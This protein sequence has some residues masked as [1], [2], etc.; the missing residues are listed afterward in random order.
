MLTYT[1]RK[2]NDRNYPI[3]FWLI[4]GTQ[5]YLD[6]IS[7][8]FVMFDDNEVALFKHSGA[9]EEKLTYV[10]VI[11]LNAS[12]EVSSDIKDKKHKRAITSLLAHV[13]ERL[14]TS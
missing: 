1:I 2:F 6:S 12:H 7:P 8:Y 14:L 9:I 13:A 11:L 10:S 5:S 4:E 3:P